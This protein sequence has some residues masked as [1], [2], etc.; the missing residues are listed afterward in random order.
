MQELHMSA[1]DCLKKNKNTIVI[2]ISILVHIG[3]KNSESCFLLLFFFRKYNLLIL[4]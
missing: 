1:D 2:I 3:R 4:R